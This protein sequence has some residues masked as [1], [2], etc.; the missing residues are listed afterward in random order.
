[1]FRRNLKIAVFIGC[2]SVLVMSC[3]GVR[4]QESFRKLTII[5]TADLQGTLDP[6]SVKDDKKPVGGI[7]RIATVLKSVKA[8]NNG[9][10]VAVSTGD[11]LMN[12]YFHAFKAKA[13]YETM[14]AAG[15]DLY[16]F[17]NHEFDKGPEVLADGVKQSG[18][19]SI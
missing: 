17:G 15:Y 10:V 8:E 9:S 2:L 4:Q 7:A 11:D 1:M 3:A 14:S 13:I 19:Q 12:K 6:I 5:G 16:A 18:F